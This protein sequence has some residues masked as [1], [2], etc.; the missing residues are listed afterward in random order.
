MKAAQLKA[1]ETIELV[2][3]PVPA[4]PPDGLLLAVKACG[5][6]GSDLRRWKEGPGPGGMTVPGHEFAGEVVEVGPQVSGYAIGDRLAVAPDVHCLKCWY[7]SVGLYNLCDD[8]TMIGIT[9]G[10]AGGLAEYCVL[11]A[12][13]LAGGTIHH[14]PDGL[15][16]TEGALGEPLSSVQACHADIGTKL[17]DTVLVM[18]AGPIGCLHTEIAHLR[19][20]RVI[21]SEPSELRRRMAEPFAPELVLDPTRQDVVAEVRA[22]T[23]G[24]GADSAICA[25]PVAATHQQ[26]VDAVRKK[27]TV[28]LFGGLP[29]AAPMT[30]LHANRIHY[31]EIRVMGSFSYHPDYHRRALQLLERGQVDPGRIV[32]H[33]FAL[34]QIE[35]VFR[36]VAA[37]EALKVM[38]RIEQEGPTQP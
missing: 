23:D 12:H 24:L 17:G 25:N 30:E 33:T 4:C 3:L 1:P 38:V 14:M 21:L 29:K 20:A 26:A 36:T 27:G 9:P 32:T 10:F 22:F 37:G 31:D 11:P 13:A 19:G 8:M 6:C 2:D 5:V 18:G 16:W 34:A 35:E 28:V 7:C 15:S